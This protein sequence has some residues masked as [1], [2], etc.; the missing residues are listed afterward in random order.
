MPAAMARSRHVIARNGDYQAPP[1][2]QIA[3]NAH[4]AL[5]KNHK[6]DCLSLARLFVC[7][8][9]RVLGSSDPLAVCPSRVNWLQP[10]ACAT[11]S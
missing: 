8:M 5:G 6:L 9:V 10:R 11:F 4:V 1:V 2:Y 3:M 7:L